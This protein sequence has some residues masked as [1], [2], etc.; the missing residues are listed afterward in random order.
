MRS[1]PARFIPPINFYPEF[2]RHR[3][4]QKMVFTCYNQAPEREEMDYSHILKFNEVAEETFVLA[5]RSRKDSLGLLDRLC[6]ICL[7]GS[8]EEH[9]MV[10]VARIA[11][12]D[13]LRGCI[14]LDIHRL[15][16]YLNVLILSCE[17]GHEAAE[18]VFEREFRSSF[19]R[20]KI[21]GEDPVAMMPFAIYEITEQH[22]SF[23]ALHFKR[24]STIPPAPFLDANARFNANRNL[25]YR[26]IYPTAEEDPDGL[27]V[28]QKRFLAPPLDTILAY[29]SASPTLISEIAPT[30]DPD[31]GWT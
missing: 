17:D 19:N 13:W 7:P 8:G 31:S 2:F 27:A 28:T 4:M 24:A 25:Y 22:L 23:E 11:M 10:F 12:R 21:I 3:R 6:E 20:L 18:L 30:E 26:S 29:I 14:R 9:I 5:S 15:T 1:W 16:N